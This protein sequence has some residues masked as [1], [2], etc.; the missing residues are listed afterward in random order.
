MAQ[1]PHRPGEGGMDESRFYP[2][3]SCCHAQHFP[4]SPWECIV[5]FKSRLAAAER[6]LAEARAWQREA[7]VTLR[8]E[9]QAAVV[10][11]PCEVPGCV[12]EHGEFCGDECCEHGEATLHICGSCG[13]EA[14]IDPADHDEDC[15][16]RQ[17][18]LRL[19]R[20]IARADA[21]EGE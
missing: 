14:S 15:S 11:C 3:C 18:L 7:V 1:G 20:L 6:E 19:S 13:N 4:E 17:P 8:A 2:T 12:V 10:E 9:L 21:Q 16:K 5:I